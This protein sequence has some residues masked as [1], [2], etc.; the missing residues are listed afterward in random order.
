MLNLHPYLLAFEE[1]TKPFFSGG[2]AHWITT[3]GTSFVLISAAEIGDKSQLVCMTLAARYQALPVFLGALS[4]FIILNTL[5]VSFGAAISSWI[6]H[7]I[8][9]GTVAL[10]F[11]AFGIH[12]LGINTEEEHINII[13]KSSHGVFLTTLLLITFAEFGDKTQLAVVA[14]SS[15]TLAAA[16][17]AGATVALAGTS[18][19]G[20]LA[21]RTV[22]Q[23]ISLTLLHRMSGFIFLIL[24]CFAGYNALV[25]FP[26]NF[27]HG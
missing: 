6:P 2:F 12:A 26:D 11:A 4:A 17:W 19:L 15:T 20:I 13:K 1:F 9:A 16:V 3:A 25:N 24:A 18:A 8:V 7:Y 22:L 10:L 23:T 27:L 21:G 5:A 14:L